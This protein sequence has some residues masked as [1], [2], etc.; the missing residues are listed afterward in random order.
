MKHFFK[1][2]AYAIESEIRLLVIRDKKIA[3]VKRDWV[4]TYTNSVVNPIITFN[5]EDER[6]PLRLK[7]VVLGPNCP[8]KETNQYQL[9]S[10]LKACVEKLRTR[11]GDEAAE[12][13][14]DVE[15]L[16][17]TIDNYRS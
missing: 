6:L 13:L 16:L 3:D 10:L 7:K 2:S 1:A 14:A 8:E 5:L 4:M 17:S 9:Q 15:I 12:R 11:S